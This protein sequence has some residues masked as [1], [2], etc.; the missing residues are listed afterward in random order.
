MAYQDEDDALTYVIDYSAYLDGATIA[1]VTRTNSGVTS[2][3]TSNTTTRVTQRLSNF[4]YIDIAVVTSTGDT[5]SMRITIR[6]R[7]GFQ[8][9]N[10]FRAW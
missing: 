2:A 9:P 5:D 1:S 3:A 8:T 6:P 7:A 4:G 10:D